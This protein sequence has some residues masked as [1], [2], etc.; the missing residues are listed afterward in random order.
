MFAKNRVYMLVYLK[1]NINICAFWSQQH[2]QAMGNNL[3]L[4]VAYR[5]THCFTDRFMTLHDMSLLKIVTHV[6]SI[7]LN[8][9]NI[10]RKKFPST[11]KLVNFTL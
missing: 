2:T 5:G 3:S 6:I 10:V 11:Y 1:I 9:M 8:T 4:F 7:F